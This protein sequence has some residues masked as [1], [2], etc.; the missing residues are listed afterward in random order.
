MLSLRLWGVY[1][2][3][4]T[5]ACRRSAGG[6]GLVRAQQLVHGD[7]TPRWSMMATLAM[8]YAASCIAVSDLMPMAYC[9]I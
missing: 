7:T 2:G 9:E 5:S 8:R 3:D 6:A 1:R 4:V